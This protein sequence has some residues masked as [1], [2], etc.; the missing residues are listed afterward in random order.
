MK[1][2]NDYIN[3]L[4][5]KIGGK[6]NE[7]CV[8]IGTILWQKC[9]MPVFYSM[10]FRPAAG[11]GRSCMNIIFPRR[12]ELEPFILNAAKRTFHCSAVS[13]KGF[14]MHKDP[15]GWPKYNE[16][17]YPPS[18]P[19]EPHRPAVSRCCIFQCH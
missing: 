5:L 7:D 14:D 13:V 15:K 12:T 1:F 3:S 16:I 2:L 18:L 9:D 19:G 11:L 10:C 8:F 17:V 4:C 6:T